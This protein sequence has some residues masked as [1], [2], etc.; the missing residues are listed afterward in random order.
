MAH[1]HPDFGRAHI[2]NRR[3]YRRFQ[4]DFRVRGETD[5]LDGEAGAGRQRAAPGYHIGDRNA[6]AD[7]DTPWFDRDRNAWPRQPG[8][9]EIDGERRAVTQTGSGPERESHQRIIG[10]GAERAMG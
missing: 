6:A 10:V 9:G 5:A 3:A 8:Y 1:G 4:D 7:G 2:L